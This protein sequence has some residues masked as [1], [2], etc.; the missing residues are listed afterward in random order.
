MRSDA[1]PVMWAMEPWE[2]RD[3]GSIHGLG[4]GD[5]EY[6][7]FMAVAALADIAGD[8]LGIIVLVAGEE[9]EKKEEEWEYK[10][11]ADRLLGAR[12]GLAEGVSAT[13]MN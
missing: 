11:G 6:E 1:L 4:G 10:S 9:G 13:D 2:G 8:D 12:A 7:L 5:G 3:A